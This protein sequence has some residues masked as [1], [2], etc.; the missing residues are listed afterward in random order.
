LPKTKKSKKSTQSPKKSSPEKN[1]GDNVKVPLEPRRY[2]SFDLNHFQIQAVEAVDAG[3]SVL[4]SAPTGSGKT[5]IAEYAVEKALEQGQRA[6]YTA[7]IK[8]L[9][10]QKYRDFRELLGDQVGLMTGDITLNPGA[11]LMIMTTEIFRNTIFEGTLRLESVAF[12][13]FDEIHFMDDLERGTV[14]EESIIFAPDHIRFICLSATIANLKEFGGWISMVRGEEIE[15][16]RSTERPVPLINYLFFP[17]FG[18]TRADKIKSFPQRTKRGRNRIDRDDLLDRL[19]RE[20]K[21]PVLYFCFSRKECEKR[22][23]TNRNRMLLDPDER[24]KIAALLDEVCGLYATETDASLAELRKLALEGV[25]YHHAGLLPQHKEI[26]E[27]LFTSGLL[28]LLY[29]TETFALGINMP[30]HTVIFSS[31]RKFDGIGF[32]VLMTR[33]YQ[34]MAGRAGRQGIDREGLVYAII[35]DNRVTLRD[36]KKLISN[37]VEPIRSRFNLS[38]CTLI[39]LHAHLGAKIFDAWEQ[40]FNNFQWTRMSRKKREKNREKQLSL[41]EKKLNFLEQLEY[42]RDDRVTERGEVA[43]LINGFEIQATELLFSG[44]LEELDEIQINVIV[45]ALVFEERKN[46][47]FR[48][49]DRQI[50]GDYR[51]RVEQT[52][53]SAIELEKSLGIRSTVKKPS[54]KAAAV[55]AGWCRGLSFTDLEDYTNATKGDL[56]RALRLTVQLLRQIKKAMP[57][58]PVLSR[59]LSTCI[60]ILNRDAVDALR[61]LQV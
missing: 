15:V 55:I 23:R 17:G 24:V 6:I 61:Q 40:S 10:N 43:A 60:E 33:Q 9:S 59:K 56:V 11:P 4:V 2:R 36:V 37:D 46:E 52:V 16:I 57:P 32:D 13:I 35:D 30:A 20:R 54:F 47:L 34:Q 22:A 48:K 42:I 58:N 25:G 12:V 38:Y 7:P 18:P 1:E 21:L 41:I 51:R 8:A 49:I 28:K 19:Q 3:R 5:L 31:L 14:W 29:T 39:N 26:V 45:N 50:L 44:F 53:F 27:R